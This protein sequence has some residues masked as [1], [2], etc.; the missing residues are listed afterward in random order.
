VTDPISIPSQRSFTYDPFQKQAIDAIDAEKSLLV[1]APTGSGKTLI[2]EYA[3][4]KAIAR[5]EKAIYTA[6]IKALSNQK[7]RDFRD[8]YGDM[9]GILTGDVSINPN[10]PILI[11]TTEI[12]RNTLFEDPARLREIGW[13][14]FD[15]VHYLD[16][17]D[18]GTVWEES[19]ILTPPQIRMLC[20][21][22]TVPNIHEVGEWMKT[23]L[24]RDVEVIV[25]S[26]RPVPLSYFFQCQG[27]LHFSNDELKRGGYLGRES[28]SLSSR[29]RRRGV[30]LHAKANRLAPLIRELESK[31]RLPALYFTFGR[32]RTETLAWE[33]TEF[34]FL[35]N[36]ERDQIHQLTSEL[37][38][39]YN[40][41][42]EHSAQDI[43]PLLRHG[44]AF[45]HAG[46]LPT[47]KEVVERLFTSRL[48]KLIFATETFALGI[49]MPA[50]TV[51]F[52]E[53]RKFYGTGF[54]T[55][56]TR[57]FYQMA[58]RAGRRGMD[59][60][61]FVA[62][63]LH[64]ND[65]TYP[66]VMRVLY[67]KHEPVISQF[68]SAYATLLNLHKQ[69]GLQLLDI[70]PRTLHHYQSTR[71]GRKKA[72]D[73]LKRKLALLDELGYLLKEGL[74]EKG[75]FASWIYGYELMTAELHATGFLDDLSG[76]DLIVLLASL[77]YEPR[78]GIQHPRLQGSFKKL[79]S[80]ADAAV[81]NIYSKE[82]RYRVRP[83]TKPAH[84]YLAA[85]MQA[86]T[87]GADFNALLKLT[88]ADEGEIVRYI[89]MVI[90]LLRQLASAPHSS[91]K[92]KVTCQSAIGTI[93]RGVVDA[94]KQLRA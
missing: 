59:K 74:T 83:Y 25:E 19:I 8:R 18:R 23:I 20:L 40:L 54:A 49:N 71:N 90:Q 30:R 48:I 15:E 86:W 42:G 92:L 12:Y 66:E 26:H 16:D 45:H 34:D 52:D 64:P 11:M 6:P 69:F 51:I 87:R 1:A 47:L 27:R 62:V 24:E 10:A 35:N 84:F 2:A 89:R 76:E 80:A 7:Y 14:I 78:K 91:Q 93:N 13:V 58:G 53:L 21:S 9:I 31:K 67:G 65:I 46:M 43:L 22:A 85:A 29:E 44:I 55:L 94:E 70:Y 3:L 63:R 33:C 72:L 61:G 57:D 75:E 39:Q 73:L 50:R 38:E 56:R 4:E 5:G 37:Y 36:A 82:K 81:R 77:I 41:T 28:W 32:R 88:P 68:N 79:E 17:W 60:E